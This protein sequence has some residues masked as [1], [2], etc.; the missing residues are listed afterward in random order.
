MRQSYCVLSGIVLALVL[1]LLVS[2]VFGIINVTS[3]W[4]L[5]RFVY[6]ISHYLI[7]AVAA[8]FAAKKA[9]GQ[10]WLIGFSL[11]LILAAI[12]LAVHWSIGEPIFNQIARSLITLGV[13]T[14]A[15]IFGVNI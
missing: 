13:G 9:A 3:V 15:G 7:V 8:V 5:G 2:L 4:D 14:I 6:D 12:S 1:Y 10:G 11:A